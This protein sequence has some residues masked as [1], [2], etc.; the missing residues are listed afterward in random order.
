[1]SSLDDIILKVDYEVITTPYKA[2]QRLNSLPDYCAYDFETASKFTE[3]EKEVF[4]QRLY[5]PNF[6]LSSNAQRILNQNINANGLSHPLLS[7][8]THLAIGLSKTEAIVIVCKTIEIKRVLFKWLVNTDKIQIWHNPLFDFKHIYFHTGRLPKT[9]IDTY[10][11]AKSLLNNAD[12]WESRSGLKE[13]MGWA[14]GDWGIDKGLFTLET[15]MDTNKI[16]YAA[17]DGCAT[18]YLYEDIQKD[19]QSWSM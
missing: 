13:L 3:A 18:K 17:T 1:M 16:K 11:L 7:T 6:N 8:I 12:N 15:I 2:I 10:L 4:K 9:F 5:N 19:L 14:Y